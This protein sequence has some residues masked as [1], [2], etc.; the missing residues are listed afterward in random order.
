[1]SLILCSC[2]PV[3]YN[4]YVHIVIMGLLWTLRPSEPLEWNWKIPACTVLVHNM[5]S[6]LHS[7]YRYRDHGDGC[8][9]T[10]FLSINHSFTHTYHQHLL[11]LRSWFLV[12]LTSFVFSS[13]VLIQRDGGIC[14]I[15]IAMSTE[16]RDFL[17]TTVRYFVFPRLRPN[18]LKRYRQIGYEGFFYSNSVFGWG[19]HWLKIADAAVD[20]FQVSMFVS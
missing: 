12:P 2:W 20:C 8:T 14:C 5:W 10:P 6:W 18:A 17:F 13:M 3:L 4:I 19:N 9:K 1:M 15:R 7:R 16:R 11:F